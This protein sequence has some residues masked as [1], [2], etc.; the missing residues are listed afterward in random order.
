MTT[1]S[2]GT[3]VQARGGVDYT[4]GVGMTIISLA[5]A[6]ECRAYTVYWLFVSYTP[7]GGLTW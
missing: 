7:R 5:L 2:N 1:Y 4:S 3:G 6:R